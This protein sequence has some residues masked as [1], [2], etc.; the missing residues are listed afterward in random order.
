MAVGGS[1]A[2]CRQRRRSIWTMF[3]WTPTATPGGC[4][5]SGFAGWGCAVG[6]A[7]S[8]MRSRF[9]PADV[10]EVQIL[11]HEQAVFCTGSVEDN[12]IVA[13][14]ERLREDVMTAQV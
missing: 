3:R 6:S 11:C 13:P 10:G 14:G 9:E 2:L 5:R 4:A 7:D 8:G 1:A 12:G